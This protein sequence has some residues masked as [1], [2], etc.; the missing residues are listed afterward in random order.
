[1][2]FSTGLC[3]R[4]YV[5]FRVINLNSAKISGEK[6]HRIITVVLMI[7]MSIMTPHSRVLFEKAKVARLVKTLLSVKESEDSF[8]YSQ[9]H[10]NGPHLESDESI[11]ILTPN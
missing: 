9:E 4:K 6:I 10:A 11:H 7:I 8:P 1:M 3:V 5:K 2:R